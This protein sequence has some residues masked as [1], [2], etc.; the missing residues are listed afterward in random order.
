MGGNSPE[1]H[2]LTDSALSLLRM[3]VQSLVGEL[4][5]LKLQSTAKKRKEKKRKMGYLAL[6]GSS[7]VE[8]TLSGEH[9][10]Y[11]CLKSGKA[12]W[13]GRAT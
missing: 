10:C 5:A 9:L 2:W 12:R 7:Q 6:R 13:P 1:T 8:L 3:W 11:M 4:R